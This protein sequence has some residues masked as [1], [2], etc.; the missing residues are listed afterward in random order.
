VDGRECHLGHD[1]VAAL[2]DELA[3]AL[4]DRREF[5]HTVGVRREDGAYVVE[6]AN[7]DSAGHRKVF[8]SFEACRRLYDRLP[9][10]A[11]A[12]DVSATG[13]T[14]GRRHMLLWHFAEHPAFDCELA[15]R[16]PLTVAK[17]DTCATE[18]ATDGAG[19]KRDACATDGA[20][21]TDTGQAREEVSPAAD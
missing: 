4:T 14:G 10:R 2:R 19:A 5:V 20:G 9:D 1:E 17:R 8:D 11:T 3:A 18:G 7:A 16:Q 13:V 6:R 21:A 15:A 12:E